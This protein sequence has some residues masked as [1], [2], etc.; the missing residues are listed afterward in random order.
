MTLHEK[1]VSNTCT[2]VIKPDGKHWIGW[3]E[4]VPGVTCQAESRDEQLETLQVTLAEAIQLNR[5]SRC[6]KRLKDTRNKR[7]GYEPPGPA[8]ALRANGCA[9]VRKGARHSWWRNG[10]D[11]KR[12]SVPRHT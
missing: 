2:A 6:V 12:S 11:T 5:E 3:I 10:D 9:L 4:E 7:F 1:R 8:L